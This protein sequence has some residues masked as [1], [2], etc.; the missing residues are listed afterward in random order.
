MDQLLLIACAS[1][2][3]K[4]KVPAELAGKKAKCPGCG[5]AVSVPNPAARAASS[6]RNAATAEPA[7]DSCRYWF[8]QWGDW[9]DVKKRRAFLVLTKDSLWT[10]PLEGKAAKRAEDALRAGTPAEDALG[11]EAVSVPY[12]TFLEVRT[13]KHHPSLTVD[14]QGEEGGGSSAFAFDDR[15]TRD[16]VFAEMRRRFAGWQY[17]RDQ[18]TPLR[19]AGGPLIAMGVCAGFFVLAAGL[20]VWFKDWQVENNFIGMIRFVGP[21]GWALIGAV[22]ILGLSVWMLVRMRTPPD[23]R[24]LRPP[25]EGHSPGARQWLQE[26]DA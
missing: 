4:L 10:V 2:G 19:A 13:N 25:E 6:S 11:G 22:V 17:S 15:E 24:Y 3:K 7:G 5:T 9:S 14:Y 1:C 12:A 21:V 8:F 20:A 23:M 16:E 26:D 18:L